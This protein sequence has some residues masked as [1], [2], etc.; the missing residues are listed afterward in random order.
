MPAPIK[1]A[2]QPEGEFA[3]IARLMAPLAAGLPGAFGLT[4]DAACLSAPAGEVLVVTNDVMV[5]GVHYLPD[6]PPD[7]VARKMLRVNLSDLAAMGAAPYAYVL[8][9]TLAKSAGAA[10]LERFVEGLAADQAQFDIALA[11]GDTVAT[12]GPTVLSLTAFGTVPVDAALRRNGAKPGDRVYVSGTIGD[13]AL[14]LKV[15]TGAM[16]ELSIRGHDTLAQRYRLPEPRIALGQALRGL[17]HAVIDVSDGLVADFGHICETSSVAGILDAA[18]VPLSPAASNAIDTDGELL[19]TV[20]TGGDDYELLFTAPPAVEAQVLALAGICGVPI[21]C[22]GRVE[23]GAGTQVVDS[24]G[25]AL[26]LS[27]AGYQ[28]F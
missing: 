14:G 1:P 28:H 7:L 13:A 11:G 18:H 17:A 16:S 15:L 22:I 2:D 6:D 12:D 8:G 24:A 25:R 21:T 10:W 4:D 20:L 5:S 23:A 19:N 9:L 3:L 26:M 27:R